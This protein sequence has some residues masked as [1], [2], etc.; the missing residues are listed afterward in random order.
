MARL[1]LPFDIAEKAGKRFLDVDEA[2]LKTAI[3]KA[4]EITGT[5][6]DAEAKRLAILVN[7][8]NIRYLKGWNTRLETADEV[9]FVA[10]S[11]GG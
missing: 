3:R 7:G 9:W 2:D 11:G 4:G 6:L 5:D 10:G 1:F 8:R